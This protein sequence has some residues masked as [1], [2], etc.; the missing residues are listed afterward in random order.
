MIFSTT[1][2]TD[3]LYV[4]GGIGRTSLD[5]FDPEVG[6]WELLQPMLG[7]RAWA[8][9]AVLHGQLCMYGGRS[10]DG[11]PLSSVERFDPAHNTWER[12][13]TMIH[14]RTFGS[15]VAID[16][17]LFVCGGQ[18]VD[19]EWLNSAECFEPAW[20]VGNLCVK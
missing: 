2:I 12:L 16:G 4:C 8:A 19:G 17:R 20:G 15:G 3:R 7:A 11:G 5:R 14:A 1:V 13:T 18:G 9:V 10:G 6:V